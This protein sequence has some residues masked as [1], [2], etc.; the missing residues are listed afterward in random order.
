MVA[1]PALTVGLLLARRHLLEGLLSGI[2]AATAIGLVL[3]LLE[4]GQL[5]YID[6]ENFRA[7][8]IV[9]AGLERGV[10]ASVF[11]LFLMGMVA[12]VEAAG[13]LERVVEFARKRTRS[14]RGAELWIFGT[15]AAAVALTTHSAVAILTVGQFTRETGQ[16]FGLSPSR[17]ANLLDLTVCSFPFNLPYFVPVILAASTTQS[18]ADFGMPRVSPFAAGFSNFHS[19][20]L[21]VV[22]VI[23]IVTGFGRKPSAAD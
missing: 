2:L 3:G 7:Q 5:L 20:M 19:W 16:R 15:V 1:A 18:G 11:T 17:R 10:G 21:L 12:S 14:A 23:A 6:S 22:A 13:I 9:L 8:G 4:P